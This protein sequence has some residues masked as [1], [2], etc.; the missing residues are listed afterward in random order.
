[1]KL[2]NQI[3]VL[4]F[5]VLILY[6]AKIIKPDLFKN[7]FW[8]LLALVIYNNFFGESLELFHF[9]VS[10]WKLSCQNAHPNR[11]SGCCLAGFNGGGHVHFEYTSDADSY[12]MLSST[13]RSRS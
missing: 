3:S 9:E 12:G 4:I 1:M 2:C 13:Y 10:P 5:I 11:C 7:I 6:Y 8:V